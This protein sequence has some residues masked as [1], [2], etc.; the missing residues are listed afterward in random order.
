MVLRTRMPRPIAAASFVFAALALA[1]GVARADD[2]SPRDE[3]S[4]DDVLQSYGLGTNH[5]GSVAIVYTPRSVFDFEENEQDPPIAGTGALT[6]AASFLPL[7]TL[8][9]GMGG[10]EGD[11]TI[12]FPL[13]KS[14]FGGF[15]ANL[16]LVVQPISFRHLRVSLAVGG[17]FNA[18]GY[19]YLKP[20]IAFTIV[21]DYVDAEAT[22]RWIPETA[23]NVFGGRTDGLEDEGFGEHKL[24]AS[25]F[26]SFRKRKD[27]DDFSVPGV[28][29]FFEYT[30]ISGDTE[31]LARVSIRPGDYMS[32]GLGAAL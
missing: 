14:Y 1:S 13:F 3:F 5:F 29:L 23:S 10:M 12:G 17:G 15:G 24:R 26:V 28:H 20:R 31:E 27:R 11:I 4:S 9:G 19:G 32:F 25:L 8:F 2:W 7:P 21:P 16:G 6:I 22:Y 18:H 30:R